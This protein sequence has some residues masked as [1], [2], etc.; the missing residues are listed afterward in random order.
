MRSAADG[1]P[2]FV[3]LPALSLPQAGDE[4]AIEGEEAHY[5]RRVVRIRPGETVTATDGR[6]ALA[7]LHVLESGQSVRAEVS[8]RRLV[9]RPGELRLWCGAPEGDR[10]DWLVEKL[11][12]LGVAALQPVDAERGRWERAE[13][14]AERWRRL[15]IAALRQSR[16]AYLLEILP[17]RPLAELLKAG[18]PEGAAWLADPAGTPFNPS[19]LAK[20]PRATAA[21]GPSSGFSPVELK[22]LEEC[23]FVAIRLTAGRLRTETAALALSTLVLASGPQP[24]PPA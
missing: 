24:D 7:E 15:A 1:S 2:S 4:L 9:R 23:G 22:R 12:E 16:S 19:G 5:L 3:Y 21:V 13:S 10:A 20:A 6:G 17:A 14:R 8:A 11:A 18:S